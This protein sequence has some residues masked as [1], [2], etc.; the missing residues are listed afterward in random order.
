MATGL[1]GT[2]SSDWRHWATPRG[3]AAAGEAI[4]RRRTTVVKASAPMVSATP[5]PIAASLQSN[6]PG[7]A[8]VTFC[9][10]EGLMGSVLG[11]ASG[12]SVECQPE[13]SPVAA[14]L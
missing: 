11:A 8:T 3:P 9:A 7:P 13:W 4:R 12:R 5:A 2:V 10:G 1:R 6:P 14:F